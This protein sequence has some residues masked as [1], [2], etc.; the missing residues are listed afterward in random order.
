MRP[1]S[2]QPCGAMSLRTAQRAD[3][4]MGE[5]TAHGRPREHQSVRN[6]LITRAHGVWQG[7]AGFNPI[8]NTAREFVRGPGWRGNRA[9]ATVS[10]C[11]PSPR[12]MRPPL[13]RN[14]RLPSGETRSPCEILREATDMGPSGIA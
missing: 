9:E 2:V 14:L 10:A 6:R 13:K 5:R 11:R 1:G 7:V 12:R 8:F 3:M 4:E